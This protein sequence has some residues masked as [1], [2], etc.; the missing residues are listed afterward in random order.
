[1]KKLLAI[2][3]VFV[4]LVSLCACGKKESADGTADNNTTSDNTENSNT[5][6]SGDVTDE[7]TGD[8]SGDNNED[9][10]DST[11]ACTHEWKD[12][13][14]TAPKTCTK[15]SATEGS[16]AGHS[17]KD[18]TCQAPK[19]C[20]KCNATEGG[21]GSHTFTADCTVC[22]QY[23]EGYVE[24]GQSSWEYTYQS[25]G[26]LIKGYY[27]FFDSVAEE[28]V[29]VSFDIYKT[30]AKFGQEYDMTIDE[31]RAEYESMDMIV[32]IDGVEYIRD[33]W[34]MDNYS[35]RRYKEENGVVTVEF[36]RVTWGENDD[37]EVVTVDKTVV[38]KRTGLA[39]M[40][41]TSSNYNSTPVGAVLT[42]EYFGS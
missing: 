32:T 5:Q 35:R 16:A 4:M 13:T 27:D 17:W 20:T 37:E 34:G 31:I 1:M 30:L 2:L 14:C 39:Q 25:E 6:G 21:K 28:G 10:S 15:C 38:M 11:P 18:A 7:S 33:G 42:G 24:L 3:L 40:T 26:N 12:A 8:T 29:N 19:T 36:L 23:N 22:G 9:N 41:V